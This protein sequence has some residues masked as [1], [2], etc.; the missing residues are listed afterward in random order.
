MDF[1][2]SEVE[3]Y[4]VYQAMM[5]EVL[6]DADG[7]YRKSAGLTSAVISALGRRRADDR[8]CSDHIANQLVAEAI[9]VLVAGIYYEVRLNP[10][11]EPELQ[12]ERIAG[13]RRM[14][15]RLVDIAPVLWYDMYNEEETVQGG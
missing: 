12:E 1:N 8:G 10:G 3:E 5:Y 11:D 14:L 4:A 9:T 7:F 2:G 15:C 6:N 13:L